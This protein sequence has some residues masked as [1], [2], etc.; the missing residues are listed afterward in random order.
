MGAAFATASGGLF[1]IL[2]IVFYVVGCLPLMGVF[3]KADH[4]GWA[5]FVPI[6][7]VLV[8]LKLVGR[9]WWWL[10]LFLIPFVGIIFEIIVL[11]DLSKSFGHGGGFTVGLFFLGWIFL[12]I[13]WLGRS[14]YRGPGAT[15]TAPPPAGG[16]TP[17]PPAPG[18]P[19]P[20][21]P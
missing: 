6:Y 5:A 10:L 18:F 13:L 1:F 7:N 8:L 19:P 21:A 4:P 9:H 2:F 15:F 16:F 12:M 17:P 20:P 3:G 11:H 14:Q